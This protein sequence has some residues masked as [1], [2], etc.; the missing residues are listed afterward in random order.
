MSSSFADGAHLQMIMYKQFV[1]T[2]HII[3]LFDRLTLSQKWLLFNDG[4]GSAFGANK[5]VFSDK[6]SS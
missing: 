2:L 6:N 5:F 4:N 3:S 1:L